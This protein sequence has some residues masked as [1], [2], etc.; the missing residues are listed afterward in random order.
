MATHMRG[1]RKGV[2]NP[3]SAHADA[4]GAGGAAPCSDVGRLVL[5]LGEVPSPA[6][7]PTGPRRAASRVTI[8]TR[9]KRS[10]RGIWRWLSSSCRSARPALANR[11]DPDVAKSIASFVGRA[12]DEALVE[13]HRFPSFATRRVGSGEFGF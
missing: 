6:G 9:A 10:P 5:S 2:Q 7:P 12:D 3:G 11:G 13:S 4:V 1:S 8:A